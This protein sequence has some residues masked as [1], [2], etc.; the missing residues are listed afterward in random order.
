MRILIAALGLFVFG[1]QVYGANEIDLKGWH[2]VGWECRFKD[3]YGSKGTFAY[4]T[5][6]AAAHHDASEHCLDDGLACRFVECRV[7]FRQAGRFDSHDDLT[8]N[9][10]DAQTYSSK[11]CNEIPPFEDYNPGRRP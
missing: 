4:G 1:A 7:S 3:F 11:L 6:A 9:P 8:F 10:C 5:T 2:L